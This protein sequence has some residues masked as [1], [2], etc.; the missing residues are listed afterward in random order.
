MKKTDVEVMLM[1]M[2]EF[3]TR[4]SRARCLADTP[5]QTYELTGIIVAADE[6]IDCLTEYLQ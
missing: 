1:R 5:K 6:L 4:V 2:K 3:R